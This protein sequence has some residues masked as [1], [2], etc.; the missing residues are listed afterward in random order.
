MDINKEPLP[1]IGADGAN[2]EKPQ[3]PY[4]EALDWT[5][6]L[7]FS[8]VVIILVFSFFVRIITVDGESMERT[9][10]TSDKVV[11]TT[12]GYEPE[13]GDIVVVNMPNWTDR[14]FI[15]RIIATGGQTVDIDFSSGKVIVD[16]QTLNEP[17]INDIIRE[18]VYQQ[19]DFPIVVPEGTVFV[20]GD[21]RNASTDSRS[22][23]IGCVDERYVMGKAQFRIFPVSS[24][25]SIYKNMG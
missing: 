16:G 15:K 2:E 24:L 14:P 12:V 6:A 9:L 11:L 18:A 10:H 22:G 3:R 5:E 23:L 8:L 4:A 13:Y 19:I 1:E 7:V 21:N 20:M 25:G 17:Y